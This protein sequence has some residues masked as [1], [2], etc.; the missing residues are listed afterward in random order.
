MKHLI[1]TGMVVMS[2]C[3]L[4]G[5]GTATAGEAHYVGSNT[6]F[7][8][9]EAQFNDWQA[10][11]HPWKLRKAEKARYS[12]LPL[13]PG[14]RWE[15]ISYVIGGATKK[16][17][18]IDQK[19][20]IITAAKDGSEARTQYNL[21]DG[22]WSFYHKGQKKPYKC[23]PCHMT[24][25]S[26]QGHQDG[27]PGMIGTWQE[28]GIGCEECH[29]PGSAHVTEPKK[30]K[31]KVDTTA[32][33]CG[34]CHQRGGLQPA[35]LAKGGFIRHHEQ[36]NELTGGAHKDLSCMECHDP[37]KRAI[38]IRT[39]CGE[40]HQDQ[41]A[42]YAKSLHGKSGI[43]CIEC[44]MARAAKSAIKTGRKAG[45]VRSH[46]FTINTD[47]KAEMF[48][49]KGDKLYTRG[50]L[51][52]DFACLNCHGSRDINWAAENVQSIHTK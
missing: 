16:A 50:Y 25:Y 4:S 17:R 29:G 2:C 6:C 5:G 31:L 26:K 22:T 47:P 10:S 19:G 21:E 13:P 24:A 45:D 11:G 15:D 48:E 51:T 44:H 30:N 7:D 33:S 14:Y 27:L 35:A 8:C 37:H 39:G 42:S 41:T 40:C 23:G 12:G 36:F 46:L 49:K 28:D 38:L 52:L 9:H 34:K 43:S 18:F 32:E 3:L 20:F 1:T